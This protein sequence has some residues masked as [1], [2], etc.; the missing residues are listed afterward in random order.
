MSVDDG[1]EME[2]ITSVSKKAGAFIKKV[3]KCFIFLFAEKAERRNVYRINFA[4]GII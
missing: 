2:D 4:L 3:R 1:C